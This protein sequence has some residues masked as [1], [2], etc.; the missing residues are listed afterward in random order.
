MKFFYSFLILIIYLYRPVI[1][2][3]A[4]YED[5]AK[6]TQQAEAF[7]HLKSKELAD[8]AAVFIHPIDH[9]LNLKKCSVLLEIAPT[10]GTVKAGRNTLKVG[11]TSPSPWR[12]FMTSNI[13]VK[14]SVVVIN[15]FLKKGHLITKED[16]S[17]KKVNISKLHNRYLENDL[18]ITGKELT[19]N[20]Q[21]GSILSANN[22][23]NPILIKRGD[24]IDI[25]AQRKSFKITMKG[26][27]MANGSIGEQ[28]RVKNLRTKKIINGSVTNKYSVKVIF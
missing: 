27:A 26:I 19:R 24:H 21:A 5:H 8:N 3:D 28:I 18:N 23:T 6:I 9:R 16:I 17:F 14:K 2:A 12:I 11:C 7:L 25:I 20:L 4:L 10:S 1:A 22:L 15:H 13:E